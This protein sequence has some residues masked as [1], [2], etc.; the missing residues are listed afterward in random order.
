MPQRVKMNIS[1]IIKNLRIVHLNKE[2]AKAETDNLILFKKLVQTNEGMYPDIDNWVKKKVIPGLK[3]SERTAYIGYIN[4][5]PIISA[6]VK[7]GDH[8][9]FCHLKIAENFQANHL[10]ELFFSLMA[11]E[12]RHI[13]KEIYFTLPEGLWEKQRN[14]FESF[15]FVKA[16]PSEMQYRLFEKELKCSANFNNVWEAVLSKLPSIAQAFSI[17]GYSMENGLLMSIRPEY[18]EKL[19]SGEKRVEIRRK[20]A[21]KWKGHRITIYASRPEC[22]LV[23]EGKIEKVV[24]GEPDF[25]WEKYH[26]EIGCSRDDFAKYTDTAKQVYAIVFVDVQRYKEKMPISQ[27]SH[28]LNVNPSDDYLRPPQSYCTLSGDKS[29]GKAVSIA[30]LLQ[31]SLKETLPGQHSRL[32]DAFIK[33]PVV[34]E[35]HTQLPLIQL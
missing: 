16:V 27:L 8:S 19:M 9:K 35:Y 14:F 12:I 34:P 28:L 7:H 30:A 5:D 22:A 4:E 10:G 6:V 31:R 24:A 21:K 11:L 33:K 20:F 13:A 1:D 29:W 18:A 32:K 25:I 17:D 2:D 15:N 26:S 3:T 23:G